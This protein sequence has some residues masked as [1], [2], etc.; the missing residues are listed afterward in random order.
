MSNKLTPFQIVLIAL[1]GFFCV[2]GVTLFATYKSNQATNTST[3]VSIWGTINKDLFDAFVS[4]INNDFNRELKIAYTQLD[5][6]TFDTSVVEAIADGKGPDIIFVP[7]DQIIR[8]R[9]KIYPIPFEKYL[10]RTYKDTYVEGAEI[11]LDQS[12]IIALPF[13]LDPL[14]TYWNRDIFTESEIA[15]APVNWADMSL[16]ATKVSKSDKNSNILQSAVAFG[17][18]RNV[19]NAKE[20]ISALIMQVGSP[21]TKISQEGLTSA[22]TQA[23]AE[24]KNP[25]ADSAVLYYSDFSNPKKIVYSWNRSLPSSKEFFLRGDLATYFGFGSEYTDIR[26]KNPN[27][28]FDVSLFPQIVDAK[29]KVTF[30]KMQG[31]ALM[32]SSKNLAGAYGV[33]N[34]LTGNEAQNIWLG[35]SDFAPTRRDIIAKGSGDAV[36]TILYR[37]ALMSRAWLD[38]NKKITA[39]IF[40]A[41]IEDITTGRLSV[42]E[43]IKKASDEL[44]NLI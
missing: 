37:S 38:P 3:E 7:Q 6:N 41:M 32:G 4:K 36:G 34:Y 8:F 5:E 28:N 16:I 31:L 12:G 17:E 15:S 22:L 13:S 44:M 30:G 24:N 25:V 40:R 39:D 9:N 11:Y 10:E 14:I 26:I 21:I 19:N 27:L 29:T 18:Y 33:I 23:S 1:F 43:S 42:G 2:L 35:L 20:I